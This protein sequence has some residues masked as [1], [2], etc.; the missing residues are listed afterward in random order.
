MEITLITSIYGDYDQLKSLPYD[1]GF[2]S[3]V[4]VTDNPDLKA[5]GWN[6]VYEPSNLER[7]LAAKKARCLPWK[8][9][10]TQH[11]VWLDAAFRLRDKRLF[12]LAEL[13][14]KNYDIIAYDHPEKRKDLYEEAKFCQDWPKYRDCDIRGQVDHY[15]SLGMPENSGLWETGCIARNHTD[16]IRQFG[17]DWLEENKNWSIQDQVSFPYLIWKYKI[18]LGTWGVNRYR[19]KW[20]RHERHLI[21]D[22]K[23]KEI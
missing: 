17:C 9:V 19:T 3:A 16:Q 12:D 15:R 8:Y 22:F 13:K 6:I 1:S 14:F 2:S 4:C 7:R 18:V 11:S 20:L 21:N 5:K 10:D 23:F